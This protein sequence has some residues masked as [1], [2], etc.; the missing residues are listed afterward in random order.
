LA[1]KLDPPLPIR[2]SHAHPAALP[3]DTLRRSK[4]AAASQYQTNTQLQPPHDTL[5]NDL[6][7]HH[8][9]IN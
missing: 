7:Y 3:V 5:L 9:Y 4:R 1:I 2:V 8:H 6:H